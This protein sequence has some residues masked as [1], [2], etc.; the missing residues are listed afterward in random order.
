MGDAKN[1]VI[2]VIGASGYLGQLL[3]SRLVDCGYTVIKISRTNKG[4]GW[5]T[6]TDG[7]L[8]G[9]DVV[10]NFA[11]KAID[12]RWT[13]TIKNELWNSRIDSSDEIVRMMSLMPKR[14]RPKLYLCASGIGIFG[15][16]GEKILT[17]VCSKGDGFLADL[18]KAWEGSALAA[19]E[20]GVRVVCMRFGAVMG[21]KSKPWR[22][23]VLPYRLFI[24]GALAGGETYFSWIHEEDAL[25]AMIYCLEVENLSG[26]VNFVAKS[27]THKETASC[28][29]KVLGRPS[30]FGVPRFLIKL[31]LGEFAGGLL[32]SINAEAK[33]LTE[34]GFEFKYYEA[35]DAFK[36]IVEEEKLCR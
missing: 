14:E 19:E 31:V 33:K 15:D 3:S 2:A 10:Y 8:D 24:G 5:R 1:L 17:D 34:N 18:C 28:I 35:V 30:V 4:D 29:G 6:F 20:L 11:G 22:K 23:M 25:E 13:N 27:L 7:C 36:A 26:G 12:C 9:V 21:V 32:A 16:R